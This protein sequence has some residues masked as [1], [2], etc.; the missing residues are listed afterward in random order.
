MKESCFFV[1]YAEF[2]SGLYT[3][4]YPKK[5]LHKTFLEVLLLD[6]VGYHSPDCECG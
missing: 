5:S 3:E 1:H 4:M 6:I 2:P